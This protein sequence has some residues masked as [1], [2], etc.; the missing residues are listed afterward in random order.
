MPG[1]RNLA[2]ATRVRSGPELR[3]LS[4]EQFTAELDAL[5]QIYALAMDAPAAELPGRT[6]LSGSMAAPPFRE[7]PRPGGALPPLR[8]A[9]TRQQ[10]HPPGGLADIYSNI[11]S[12]SCLLLSDLSSKLPTGSDKT[13][14]RARDGRIVRV[15]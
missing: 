1:G 9:R 6:W 14:L 4:A 3:E 10:G 11:S 12:A 5:T 2:Y 15:R 8:P 7:A 13:P